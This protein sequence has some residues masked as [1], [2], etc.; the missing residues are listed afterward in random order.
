MEEEARQIQARANEITRAAA[1]GQKQIQFLRT[2]LPKYAAIGESSP[3]FRKLVPADDS[4]AQQAVKDSEIALQGL[5]EAG[6]AVNQTT[7]LVG[8]TVSTVNVVGNS[9]ISGI[10]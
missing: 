2:E 6:T 3:E 4:W 10:G 5:R 9:A 8:M 7:L 1:I